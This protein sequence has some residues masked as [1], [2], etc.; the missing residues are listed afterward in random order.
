MQN[1]CAG[2]PRPEYPIL[3]KAA[4]ESAAQD[5]ANFLVKHYP[6]NPPIKA[7]FPL[8]F[9]RS[10]ASRYQRWPYLSQSRKRTVAC[11]IQ[12]CD[13][14]RFHLNTRSLSLTAGTMWQWYCIMPVVA[15]IET[16]LH[17]VG[18]QEGWFTSNTKFK[19]AI[20]TAHSKGIYKQA[21]RDELHELRNY[22]NEVHLYLKNDAVEMCDGKP[23]KYNKAVKLLH[24]LEA[25]L[26]KHLGK[27]K[28]SV[29]PRA[30]LT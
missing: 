17:K 3:L 6:K 5:A 1:Q 14:N 10:L 19:R 8:G 25:Q 23:A 9:I 18:V 13:V 29:T 21:M 27:K 28:V 26:T 2:N 12:L 7:R 20:D 30:L 22:R 16:L 11:V 15:V 4:F 24:A